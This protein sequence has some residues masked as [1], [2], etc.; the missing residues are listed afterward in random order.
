TFPVLIDSEYKVNGT[1]GTGSI[2][3][4]WIVDTEGNLVARLVGATDWESDSIM[5]ALEELLPQQ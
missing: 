3:T 4:S 2:P 5:E 1:Y